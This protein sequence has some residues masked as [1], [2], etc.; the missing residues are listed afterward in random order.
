MGLMRVI[1]IFRAGLHT[2]MDGRA[3]DYP[4][5]A[6]EFC[7]NAYN[8]KSMPT[9]RAPLVLGHPTEQDSDFSLGVVQRLNVLGD[10][11]FGE[12]ELSAGLVELVRQG[13]Y[14]HVSASFRNLSM[15]GP[16]VDYMELRHVGFLGAMPPAIKGLG[17]VTI[18]HRCTG[19]TAYGEAADALTADF[20]EGRHAPMPAV[21]WA[22]SATDSDSRAVHGLA[23]EY[24]RA[25]PALGYWDAV[26][27]AARR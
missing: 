16:S 26:G 5:R 7:C 13:H 12:C 14:K 3:F 19:A 8:S 27:I 23:L 24:Q 9:W 18:D 11:L 21:D 20:A 6:L 17:P 4:V 2:A 1:K 25:I 15:W 10:A 22:P